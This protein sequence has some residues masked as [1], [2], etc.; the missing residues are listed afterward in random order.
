MSPINFIAESVS[1]F[2]MPDIGLSELLDITLLC[3]L[4]YYIMRWIRQTHAWA[5]LKGIV[6][7]VLV[8]SVAYLFQLVTVIWVVQNALAMGIIALVILFQP[9]LRKALEQL[10]RGVGTLSEHK[11]GIAS[12]SIEE[13][14][15]ALLTMSSRKTGALICVERDVTLDDVAQT[16][17]MIDAAIT[18]QLIM[19]IF[20]NNT[21]LHDGS[22][23]I[24]H[25]R[26]HA[27]ACILPLTSEDV[28]HELGTR[29]RAALG[30]S[31]VSDALVLVVSE[32]TGSISAASSGKLARHLSEKKLRNLLN[33]SLKNDNTR[34]KRRILRQLFTPS[35]RI[36]KDASES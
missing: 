36:K 16:G 15:N 1:M 26:I 22:M 7:V 30:L 24:R 34:R 18:R 21:P 5:L 28:D 35:R 20:A 25:N 13:I 33:A 23:V 19:N 3:A 12:H 8:A 10:G 14:A 2:H 32:E 11:T 9:E 6:I 27:A 17:I 29:H 4:I 31:E